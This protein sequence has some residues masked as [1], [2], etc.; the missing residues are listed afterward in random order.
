[1]KKPRHPDDGTDFI[2]YSSSNGAIN[3]MK[4]LNLDIDLER[5][6]EVARKLLRAEF[7]LPEKQDF[8]HVPN[9]NLALTIGD[10]SAGGI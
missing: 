3:S 2:L 9:P 4:H 6:T 5:L 10:R 1:M 8:W 7:P